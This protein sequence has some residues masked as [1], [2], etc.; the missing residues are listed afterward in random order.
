MTEITYR[1]LHHKRGTACDVE[2][3]EAGAEPR[4]VDTFNTEAEAWEWINE[5]EQLHK[6]ALRRMQRRQDLP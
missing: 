5:R 3:T 4:I 2:M 6:S 1:I